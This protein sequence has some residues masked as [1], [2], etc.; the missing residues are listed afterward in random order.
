MADNAKEVKVRIGL[1]AKTT[2]EWAE[3]ANANL[4]LKSG[5]M[6]I[7]YGSPNRFKIGDGEKTWAQLGYWDAGLASLGYIK[8]TRSGSGSQ[9]NYSFTLK[10][11]PNS[12]FSR[13]IK[14]GSDSILLQAGTTGI[15]AELKHHELKFSADYL[16]TTISTNGM[17]VESLMIDP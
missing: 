10:E 8:T 4:V 2:A 13:E 6:G 16:S 17:Q 11:E 15:N 9:Y 7:E 14:Y 12:A 1:L 3:T 5:E